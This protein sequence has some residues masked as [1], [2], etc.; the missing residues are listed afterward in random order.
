MG[1]QLRCAAPGS[2]GFLLYKALPRQGE[3]QDLVEGAGSASA[4]ASRS[5]WGN[6]TLEGLGLGLRLM[7]RM[8]G[9]LGV[10][11]GWMG[12]GGS[13]RGWGE[14]EE[15]GTCRAPGEEGRSEMFGE[16]RWGRPRGAHCLASGEDERSGE[17]GELP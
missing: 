11:W 8:A 1:T 17:M 15:A 10:C 5:M 9:S 14:R 4:E 12:W 7:S 2:R 16:R 13:C 6:S 3:Q